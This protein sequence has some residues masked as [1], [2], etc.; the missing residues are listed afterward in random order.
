[1]FVSENTIESKNLAEFSVKIVKLPL[2]K[3]KDCCKGS[4]RLT[5]KFVAEMAKVAEPGNP[6]ATLSAKADLKTLII[7]AKSYT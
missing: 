4:E 6:K 5:K 1:M 3:Q 2:R 7:G